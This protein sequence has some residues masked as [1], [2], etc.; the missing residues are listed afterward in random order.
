MNNDKQMTTPEVRAIPAAQTDVDADPNAD[1]D[2]AAELSTGI[3]PGLVSKAQ[4][5]DHDQLSDNIP[6]CLLM[7]PAIRQPLPVLTMLC[8]QLS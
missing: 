3:C 7:L 1:A 5:A 6:S 8:S 2:A 4:L